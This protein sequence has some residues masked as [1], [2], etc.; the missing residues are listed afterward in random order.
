MA[1]FSKIFFI[2]EMF[3]KNKTNF[4]RPIS[5]FFWVGRVGRFTVRYNLEL[6]MFTAK[7]F[8]FS[9]NPT[10]ADKDELA[11]LVAFVD[12][13]DGRPVVMSEVYLAMAE[14]PL[15]FNNLQDGMNYFKSIIADYGLEGVQTSDYRDLMLEVTKMFQQAQN[16]K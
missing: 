16:Q 12:K 14:D 2:I 3:L 13:K 15:E 5:P 8:G 6:I 11:V 7:N 10:V 1:Y 4:G 9:S